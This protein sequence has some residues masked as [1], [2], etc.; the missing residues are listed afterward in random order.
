MNTLNI[1]TDIIRYNFNN[2]QYY[3]EEHPKTQIYLHHTAGNSNPVAVYKDW[4]TTPVR[5]ATCVVIGGKPRKGD[6]HIDG[7]IIQGYPSKQF[8]YHL[9]L[10]EA[11]FHNFNLPYK[12]LDRISIGIEVCNWGQL[13]Y[14]DGKYY[15]YTRTVIEES[16]VIELSTPH[17]GFKYYH[18]ITDEQIAS[19]EKLLRYWGQKYNIPLTYNDD[20]FDICP[21]ALKGEPGVYTHNSVRYDKVDIYPHPKLIEMLKTL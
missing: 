2:E 7:Q 16:D 6:T 3:S 18:N 20:I 11:T 10:K 21:R 12:S 4:E 1:E 8:A 17:R 5:V 15:T 19:V 13:S 9:G 14:K